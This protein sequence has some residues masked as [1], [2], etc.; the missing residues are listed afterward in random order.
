MSQEEGELVVH[1]VHYPRY[2][3]ARFEPNDGVCRKRP[4]VRQHL[5]ISPRSVLTRLIVLHT[6]H[7]LARIEAH[8]LCTLQDPSVEVHS[9]HLPSSFWAAMEEE[10]SLH[11]GADERRRNAEVAS[12]ERR[13]YP[14]CST[15]REEVDALV[16]VRCPSLHSSFLCPSPDLCS[17]R[18]DLSPSLPSTPP[19]PQLA[20]S[21]SVFT[22]TPVPTLSPS[23]AAGP[24]VSPIRRTFSAAKRRATKAAGLASRSRRGPT[25]G[26]GSRRYT[27]SIRIRSRQQRSGRS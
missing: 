8:P 11:E 13:P 3:S 24:P 12:A 20:T 2:S 22:P 27:R 10:D 4:P 26:G 21:S 15:I 16:Q 7:K 18:R 9:L 19:S 23:S 5:L 1:L 14:S 6:V 17:H 25:A